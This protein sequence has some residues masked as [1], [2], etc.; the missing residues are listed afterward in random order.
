M[1]CKDALLFTSLCSAGLTQKL[2]SACFRGCW[3]PST[4]SLLR[5]CWSPVSQ[6]LAIV[7]DSELHCAQADIPSFHTL[8]LYIADSCGISPW[9]L[10]QLRPL[11]GLQGTTPFWTATNNNSLYLIVHWFHDCARCSKCCLYLLS[12][13]LTD[14]KGRLLSAFS[15]CLEK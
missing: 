1:A 3:G 12:S 7:S 6:V 8:R 15:L 9:D 14:S 13:H 11:E 4:V 10:V 2:Y 5:Y